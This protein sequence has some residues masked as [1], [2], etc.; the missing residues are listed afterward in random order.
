MLIQIIGNLDNQ[1][2][3]KWSSTVLHSL[4]KMLKAII[5]ACL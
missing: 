2:P 4:E 3:D 1:C 5:V